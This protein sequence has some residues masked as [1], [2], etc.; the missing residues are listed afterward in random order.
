MIGT[1]PASRTGES[2]TWRV[3]E[4]DENWTGV[5]GDVDAVKHCI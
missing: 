4:D 1:A 2:A 5:F 3:F